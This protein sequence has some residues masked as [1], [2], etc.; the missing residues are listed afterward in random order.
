MAA[1]IQGNTKAHFTQFPSSVGATG[2]ATTGKSGDAKGSKDSSNNI[3]NNPLLQ[4]DPA[5]VLELLTQ[6][7]QQKEL[8]LKDAKKD[9]KDDKN[10]AL[11]DEVDRQDLEAAGNKLYNDEHNPCASKSTIEN[12]FKNYYSES[13]AADHQAINDGFDPSLL[14]SG[15]D[16]DDALSIDQKSSTSAAAAEQNQINQLTQEIAQLKKEIAQIQKQI[17]E[18][19]QVQGTIAGTRSDIAAAVSTATTAGA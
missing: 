12:D 18:A 1:S 4:N 8:D 2:P 9:L 14:Q 17:N 10:E 19:K 5:A 16:I 11:R 7:L 13:L 3:E 6:K 15:R